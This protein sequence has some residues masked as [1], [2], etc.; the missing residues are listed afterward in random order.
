M[1]SLGLNVNDDGYIIKSRIIYEEEGY[2]L[3]YNRFIRC[4]HC[5][6]LSNHIGYKKVMKQDNSWKIESLKSLQSLAAYNKGV[7]GGK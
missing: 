4:P 2:Y 5:S 1:R 7:Y 6:F 3:P